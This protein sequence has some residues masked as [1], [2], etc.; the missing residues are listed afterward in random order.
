[1]KE[2][3]PHSDI[4]TGLDHSSKLGLQTVGEFMLAHLG[5]NLGQISELE[6]VTALSRP[7]VIRLLDERKGQEDQPLHRFNIFVKWLS[8]NSMDAIK[9]EEVLQTFDFNHFDIHDLA[10]EVKRS[11]LYDSDKII[12]GMYRL[13]VS[14]YY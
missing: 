2:T 11:G 3:F 7:M 9:K 6:E 4:L 12:E 13:H 8:G 14:Q 10:G 5:Q 1:M